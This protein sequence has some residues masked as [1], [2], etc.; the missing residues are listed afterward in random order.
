LTSEFIEEFKEKIDDK[1][2]FSV[3]KEKSLDQKTVEVF[4]YAETR[5]LK[6]KDGFLFVFRNHNA[7]GRG[8]HGVESYEKGVYYRDWHVDMRETEENS[9]GFGVWSE[10]EIEIKIKIEDWGVNPF[11]TTK[12]RVWGFEIV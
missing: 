4:K 3:N 1:V 7:A 5:T 8:Y 10:G 9:F 2:Q 11:N 6:V 12:G